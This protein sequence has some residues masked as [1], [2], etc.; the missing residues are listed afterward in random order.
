MTAFRNRNGFL[1]LRFSFWDYSTSLSLNGFPVSNSLNF[2]FV[3]QNHIFIS[4]FFNA[5]Q[6]DCIQKRKSIFTPLFWFLILYN[7]F[8]P[9][10]I[11]CVKLCS[12]WFRSP[13]HIFIFIFFNIAQ[14]DCIQKRSLF[15][16]Y[17]FGFRNYSTSLSL[18]GFRVS[19]FVSIGFVPQTHF[20]IHFC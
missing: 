7:E 17:C 2:G 13:N 18:N 9:K 12:F 8:V 6:W 20:F 4:I 10:S 1:R 5:A 3:P 15:L 14:C 19:N 11:P 16:R